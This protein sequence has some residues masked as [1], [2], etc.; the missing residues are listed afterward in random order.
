MEFKTLMDEENEGLMGL[1]EKTMQ[2]RDKDAEMSEAAENPEVKHKWLV[3]LQ[4]DI[5]KIIAFEGKYFL[6]A[7]SCWNMEIKNINKCDYIDCEIAF[8]GGRDQDIATSNFQEDDL[9]NI[10]FDNS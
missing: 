5:T 10:H 7:A 8:E 1:H 9:P 3:R 4:E 6:P 2:E